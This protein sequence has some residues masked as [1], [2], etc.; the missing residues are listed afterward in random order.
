MTERMVPHGFHG[1]YWGPQATK[2]RQEGRLPEISITPQMKR[3]DEWGRKVLRNGDILFRMGDARLMHGYFPMSRFLANASGS[4]FSHTA[5][6]SIEKEGPVVYDTTRTSVSRQPFCVWMLDNV[7]NFGVKRLRSEH[8]EAVPRVIEFC[9]T[10]FDKQ[11]PFDYD[12]NLDDKALYC[13]E[14][15]EKAYRYAGLK[16]SDPIKLGDMERAS[17][18]PLAIM[19]IAT[20]SQYVLDDPLTLEKEVFFPGNERHGIWSSPKLE[21]VVPPT[22]TPGYPYM[23]DHG[24]PA[25]A[26][27][28]N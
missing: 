20:A 24:L 23:A 12:L 8:R 25:V 28:A 14:M 19:G 17:E 3:W 15:T 13:V 7:G 4:K 16:L 27:S 26:A 21:V 6:V 22:F 2:A 1:N 5:I 18:F 9:Q 11:L 10:V